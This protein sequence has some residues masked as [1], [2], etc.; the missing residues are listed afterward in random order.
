MMVNFAM[1]GPMLVT[2]VKRR[3]KYKNIRNLIGLRYSNDAF[4]KPV[5][6]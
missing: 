6:Y 2:P 1:A 3:T 4:L 5:I